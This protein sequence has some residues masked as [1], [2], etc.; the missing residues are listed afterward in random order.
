VQL[1]ALRWHQGGPNGFAHLARSPD[2]EP[3]RAMGIALLALAAAESGSVGECREHLDELAAR[4]TWPAMLANRPAL[5]GMSVVAVAAQRCAHRPV[6][7]VALKAL[8]AQRGSLVV[9]PRA[10]V[11]LGPASYF[12]GLAAMTTGKARLARELLAEAEQ[13]AR[14]IGAQPLLVR[15]LAARAEM[16]ANEQDLAGL[17]ACTSEAKSIASAIAMGWFDSWPRP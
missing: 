13:Q 16:A 1:L 4:P 3:D 5:D 10:E 14:A 7:K 11:V 8:L 15:T 6:A 2:T 9:A 12:A 17:E